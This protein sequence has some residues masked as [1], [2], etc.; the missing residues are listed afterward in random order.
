M[1]ISRKIITFLYI[2]VNLIVESV[3]V[4]IMLQN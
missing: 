4:K 1:C 3:I 2:I